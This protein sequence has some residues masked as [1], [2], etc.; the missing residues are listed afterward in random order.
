[1][2]SWQE[3]F[4]LVYLEAMAHGKPV[5]AVQGQ[6]VDGIVTHGET[7]ILVKPRDIDT[8]VEALDFL[9]S[10]PEEAKAIGERSRN[11]VLKNYTWEKNA[12]RTIE[13]YHEVLNGR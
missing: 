8:L 10:H 2:P 5:V 7:G 11:M 13:V 3:T 12:K 1:M 4:G 6:G 9:L